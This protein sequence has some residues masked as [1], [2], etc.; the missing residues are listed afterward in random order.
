MNRRVPPVHVVPKSAL[1]VVTGVEED[2]ITF[3]PQDLARNAGDSSQPPYA[4]VLLMRPAT[5]RRATG[6]LESDLCKFD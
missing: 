6:L 3:L 4:F 1:E 2:G 5:A